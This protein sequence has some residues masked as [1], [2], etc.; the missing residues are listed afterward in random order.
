MKLFWIVCWLLCRSSYSIRLGSSLVLCLLLLS[1]GTSFANP[2][3]AVEVRLQD[4]PTIQMRYGT[5]SVRQLVHNT[6]LWLL[7]Q[8]IALSLLRAPDI[9]L[10]QEYSWERNYLFR[11]GQDVKAAELIPLLEQVLRTELEQAEQVNQRNHLVGSLD[12]DILLAYLHQ[13]PANAEGVLTE[14]LNRYIRLRQQLATSSRLGFFSRLLDIDDAAVSKTLVE[15]TIYYYLL[16]LNRLNPR[17]F[18]PTRLEEQ[19]RRVTLRTKAETAEKFQ[20]VKTRNYRTEQ[21]VREEIQVDG[22]RIPKVV[23]EDGLCQLIKITE[24]EN[25]YFLEQSCRVHP[26][27]GSG[28]TYLVKTNP[29]TIELTHVFFWIS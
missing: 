17:S 29:D 9:R 18:P 7:N 4:L 23:A 20:T 6:P 8:N 16:A 21:V 5:D 14:Q 22:V 12:D 15:W 13:Q 19:Q 26:R 11:M 28:V 1:K 24:S 2:V 3:Q 27:T 25:A 10:T